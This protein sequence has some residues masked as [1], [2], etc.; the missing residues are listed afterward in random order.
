MVNKEVQATFFQRCCIIDSQCSICFPV[1]YICAFSSIL[2]SIHLFLY[3][4]MTIP[5]SFNNVHLSFLPAA[6]ETCNCCILKIKGKKFH[7]PPPGVQ[8]SWG[9]PQCDVFFPSYLKQNH[10][11]THVHFCDYCEKPYLIIKRKNKTFC[12]YERLQHH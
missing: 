6:A 7:L 11:N 10:K 5:H 8:E 12:S 1:S 4:K 3:K 2:F 9:L